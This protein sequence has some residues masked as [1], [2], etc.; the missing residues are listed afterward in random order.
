[1]FGNKELQILFYITRG[2]TT[3]AGLSEKLILSEPEVYRKIRLLRSKD[4]LDRRNPISISHC[5]H[6][7]RLA[8]M[9][10]DGP[11]MARFLSGGNLDILVSIT[12]PRTLKQIHESTGLSESHIRKMLDTLI[13]G[14]IV[15][16]INN[17]YHIND[18][19]CPKLRPFLNSFI[20]YMEV[21]DPRLSNDSEIVF[22]K[23]KDVIFS[24][25]DGQGYEPTGS[26]AF[27]LYGMDGLPDGH[28]FYT[29]EKGEMSI[30]TVFEDALHI[31]EVENDWR[32]RMANILFY[33]KNSEKLEPPQD[34]IRTHERIMSGEH[35]RNW[36]SKQD[37][38]DRMWMV[39]G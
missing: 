27:K 33:I 21:S 18:E 31:A 34:F 23:G 7:K 8:S 9:M 10:S 36:P 25:A 28:G 35:I 39:K 1:M 17:I 29:T 13:E 5:P 3:V 38:E 19:G 2:I 30:D 4:I 12:I 32:L 20:D 22:R 11:G 37:I 16:K 6:A 15:V 14:D 26:S 24:S